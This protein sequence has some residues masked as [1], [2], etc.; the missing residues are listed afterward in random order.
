MAESVSPKQLAKAIGVSE[1][2][3]KRWCDD[4]VI[5]TTYTPGGHR[6]IE[7]DEVL[8]FLR[9]SKY[10]IANPEILGLPSMLG[11]RT[12]STQEAIAQLQDSLVANN[13][14]L[15]LAIIM[16]LFLSKLPLP[17]LFD[18]IISV[19]FK[20]IGDQWNCG[21]IDIYQERQ[22]CQICRRAIDR[23]RT[24]TKNNNQRFLALGGT[25]SGD[26]YE[27]PTLMVEIALN[28]MGW[29]A[30]SLGTNIPASSMLTSALDKKANLL[31]ISVSHIENHTRFIEEM[32]ELWIKRPNQIPLVIGGQAFTPDLRREVR[33]S[34]YC[35]SIL[36][37][38]SFME[39]YQTLAT[40]NAAKPSEN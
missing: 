40:V 18:D 6:K 7:I 39:S 23:F 25:L 22:A 28:S 19:V 16:G 34:I 26:H 21:S 2:S 12:W 11:R 24:L 5:N 20:N 38:Q 3:V 35:D 33:H 37:L 15:A 31:W 9:D 10:D 8:H 13:E 4:G 14:E 36:Q 29:N 30:C 1:S 17:V 27:I 32:N